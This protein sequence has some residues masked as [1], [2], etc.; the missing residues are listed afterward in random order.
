MKRRKKIEITCSIPNVSIAVPIFHVLQLVA[1]EIV[2]DDGYADLDSPLVF[3]ESEV[4]FMLV[5]NLSFS[6][7]FQVSVLDHWRREYNCSQIADA[8][9]AWLCVKNKLS[10]ANPSIDIR[11]SVH[12]MTSWEFWSNTSSWN[13]SVIDEKFFFFACR[14]DSFALKWSYCSWDPYFAARD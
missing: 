9:S 14:V 12:S 8:L 3:S 2:N 10:W 4:Y 6:S 11:S 5:D 13:L 1:V 7:L